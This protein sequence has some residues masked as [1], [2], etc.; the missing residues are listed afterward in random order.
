MNPMENLTFLGGV[1]TI[2]Q[3]FDN[4][5]TIASGVYDTVTETLILT[6]RNGTV[7]RYPAVPQEDVERFFNA[8]S[9][10]KFFATFIRPYH[11]GTRV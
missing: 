11:Q 3:K 4:S 10:G 8:E 5:S 7:Y 1:R 2:Q 9:A 6:F